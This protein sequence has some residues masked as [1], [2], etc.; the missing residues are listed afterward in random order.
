MDQGQNHLK[1]MN[2]GDILDY[3]VDAFKQNFKGIVLLSLILYVPWIVIY[4]IAENIFIGNPMSEYFNL[5]KDFLKDAIPQNVLDSYIADANT[6]NYNTL[7]VSLFSLVQLIYS[8]TFKLVFNAAVIKMIY[9]YV[10]SGE[11]KIKTLS[12]VRSIIKDC[13]KFLPNMMG[14]AIMFV[15]ILGSAY[16]IS[17]IAGVFIVVVPIAILAP[18]SSSNPAYLAIVVILL[19]IFVILGVIIAVGFVAVKLLF[20][21]NTIVIEGKSAFQSI[22]RSFYLAKGKFWHIGFAC[23]FAFVLYYLFGSML[24][25]ASMFLEVF[26][27]TLYIV[28]NAFSNM[29][30]AIVEPFILVFITILFVNM[31]IQKEGLDLEVKMRR[32]IDSEKQAS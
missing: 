4:S 17:I 9:E 12:D 27:K 24:V 7:I 6:T 31:K 20:G 22:G 13:F 2:I 19:S 14:N 15:I 21:A 8:L 18:L 1:P 16:F 10:I 30:A 3:S 28:V 23:A 25:G 11:V 32:L 29:C 26:N 5:Y